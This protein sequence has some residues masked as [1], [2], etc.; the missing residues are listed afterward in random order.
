MGG[1]LL[2]WTGWQAIFLINVPIGVAALTLMRFALPADNSC[3]AQ[4]PGA[5]DPARVILLLVTLGAFAAA[6]T[7]GHG[8][9]PIA[10]HLASSCPFRPA[11]HRQSSPGPRSAQRLPPTSKDNRNGT[12]LS[13]QKPQL[14]R[15]EKRCP[16]HRL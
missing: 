16:L 14:R 5:F 9:R 8:G 13:Q 12:Y 7:V 4:R 2:A 11:V 3:S 1:L 10:N 6:M 15:S